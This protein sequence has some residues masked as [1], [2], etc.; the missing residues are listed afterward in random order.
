MFDNIDFKEFWNDCEYSEENYHSADFTEELL[1]DIETELG[2]KLPK[3][4]I[5][6]MKTH[7]GG[8][9]NFDCCPC[10]SP[11]SWAED[12]ICISG[13]MGIGR[14]KEYSLCGELGSQF[15]ID[16]WE[17]PAIGVAICD[18]PSA[19]HDMVF[20]D[21]RECGKDGEPCVVHVDQELDY[22]ITK[23]ANTFEE[24]INKLCVIDDDND[25]TDINTNSGFRISE[26]WVKQMA[27]NLH[28]KN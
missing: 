21:Y 23:L 13:I 2:Y 28:N 26:E 11:T 19:G 16:E 20:L 15:M 10:D 3:A 8:M 22:K 24:F 14:E 17:Y 5:E 6:L 27:A 18:C 12:H 4:Y 7:Y 9:V 1:H 25:S